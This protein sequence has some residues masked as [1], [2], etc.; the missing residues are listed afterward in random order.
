MKSNI[1]HKEMVKR[2]LP[3]VPVI[4]AVA[5]VIMMVNN[6]K[7]LEKKE[8]TEVP[9]KVRTISLES[10]DVV[11]RAI[12]Y[13]YVEPGQV[14]Q[15]IPE[16]SG[17]IVAV[18]PAFKKGS[19]VSGGEVLVRIDPTDY[20]LAASRMAANIESLKAQM[21]ELD[22]QEKNYRLSLEIQQNLLNLKQKE[23]ERNQQAMKTRS[24]SSSTLDKSLMDYQNQLAQ[25]QEIKNSIALIPSSR[26]ALKAEI[27]A[28]QVQL[29]E[30]QVDLKRTEIVVPFN[31]RITETS[32]EIGQYVQQGSSIAS[33]DGTNRAEINAQLPL[34]SVQKLIAE[35]GNEPVTATTATMDRIRMD[36]IRDLYGLKVKV[37]QVNGHQKAV[38][39]AD[40]TRTDATLD[41]QTRTLGVIIAVD[42]PYDLIIVG[43][44]PPL[45]RNMFCEVEVSGRPIVEQVV[46][47]RSALHDGRVFVVDRE[48]RLRRR[49]VEVSFTQSDFAVVR[50]GLAVGEQVVVSDLM[51]AV[52]G[53]LLTPQEDAAM[54][55]RLMSQALGLTD[56][57]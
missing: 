4:I 43:Q 50:T 17:R 52:E 2:L 3:V 25:V 57:R 53:M 27:K 20:Q 41:A 5:A 54:K 16:V 31:C 23:W 47:P 35:V 11:P 34:E 9:R 21:D 1:K 24:I 46:I 56:V 37:R 45:M 10:V 33:A 29:E 44:R 51:S 39:D 30:A 22:S 6:Q 55:K 42:N 19:F 32:A 8:A 28:T 40:F 12:G 48:N 14:W 36:K 7:G 26:N 15:V 13:G 49:S 18:S 38:W